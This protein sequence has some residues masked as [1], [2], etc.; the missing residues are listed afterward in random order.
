MVKI[1]KVHNVQANVKHAE[2]HAIVTV[3]PEQA[4]R[5]TKLLG[6]KVEVGEQ[7]DLG[8][9]AVHDK[10]FWTRL[11]ANVRIAMEHRKSLFK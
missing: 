5:L 7:F 4:E 2:L 11:K 3:G 9:V 8:A 1:P 6:R 10:S